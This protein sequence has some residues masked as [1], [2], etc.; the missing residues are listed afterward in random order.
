MPYLQFVF[1]CVVWS[2]SFLLMKKAATTFTPVEIGWW[3]VAAGSATLGAIWWLRDRCWDWRWRDAGPLA[4]VV[5]SGCAAPYAIQPWVIKCQGS[6]FMALV[7]SLVPLLTILV[8][9]PILKVVPSKRQTC[10]VF[11]ALACMTLLLTDGLRRDVTWT[12]FALAASVPLGYA[13]AN[14]VIRARLAHVPALS[15]TMMSFF[16]TA[17]VLSPLLVAPT[18]RLSPPTVEQRSLAIWS[19]AL[20]GV[21]GTGIATSVF[22][23]LVRRHGP[24][25]AGMTTNVVPLGAVLFGWLDGESLSAAQLA[26]LAGILSMVALVQYRGAARGATAEA[27]GAVTLGKDPTQN[28]RGS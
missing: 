8:S 25:F 18:D 5:L 21:L 16:L 14:T 11:G 4:L 27:T 20:L 10:G 26:S 7:V 13:L 17:V 12:Q 9:M 1:V 22:N 23:H 28:D 2:V 24:L 19:L 6:A 15:V 3:R